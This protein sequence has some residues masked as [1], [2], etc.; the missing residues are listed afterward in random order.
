MSRPRFSDLRRH[1]QR[2]FLFSIAL[3]VAQAC[4]SSGTTGGGGGGGDAIT[5]E[6]IGDP[7][8]ETALTIIRRLQPRWLRS[9][10][11]STPSD[12][13]GP[14]VGGVCAAA[15][16]PVAQVLLDDQHIGDADVLD[17]ISGTQIERIE[18]MDA[19]DATTRYG[20]NF[21]GGAIIVRTINSAR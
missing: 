7:T 8:N 12:G 6:Q 19:L 20:T 15:P 5:R 1:V 9:R 3:I 17:G 13:F 18:Y 11:Q 21:S 10:S 14:C 16:A 4:A 2:V